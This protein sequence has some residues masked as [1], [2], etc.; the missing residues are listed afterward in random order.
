MADSTNE[1]LGYQLGKGAVTTMNAVGDA[2][3]TVAGVSYYAVHFPV[4]S[5]VTVLT[6]GSSVSGTDADLQL[7]YAAGTVLFLNFTAITITSG[8]A[9]VYKNDTL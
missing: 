6:T 5:V 1:L 4:E 7:T 3:S 9:L 8:L 2:I